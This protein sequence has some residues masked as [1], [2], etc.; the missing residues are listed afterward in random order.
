MRTFPHLSRLTAHAAVALTVL[1]G[2][3]CATADAATPRLAQRVGSAA[4]SDAGPVTV[5][6]YNICGEHCNADSTGDDINALMSIINTYQPNA[7]LLQEVCGDQFNALEARSHEDGNW[8]LY[9]ATDKTEPRGCDAGSDSFG[10]AVLVHTPF[11]PGTV[12]TLSLNYVHGSGDGKQT[13]KTLC[14]LSATSF[15]RATEVCTVHAGLDFEIGARHQAAQIKQAY[16]FARGRN[17]TNPLVFGGDFNVTPSSNALD[18][19]YFT[20]GGGASGAMEEVDACPGR[21]GRSHHSSACNTYTHDATPAVKHRTKNDYIFGSH[22]SFKDLFGAVLVETTYSDH[23][24][25]V[26]TLYECSAGIC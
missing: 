3:G 1:A 7:V 11:D 17:A 25:L 12:D 16:D 6:T 4:A 26:G 2:A 19:V 21:H 14:L 22:K 23:N 10:D 9:G 15:P 24:A 13:R 5:L 8:A 18:P 20:G